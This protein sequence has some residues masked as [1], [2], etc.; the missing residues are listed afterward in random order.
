MTTRVYDASQV[1]MLFMGAIIDSGFADG[2]FLKIEQS[3]QDFEAVIG[4]DG[5]VTRYPT[6]TRHAKITIMLMQSS[7][8][9]SKLSAINNLDIVSHNGAGIGPMFVRDLLGTSIY[10]A[11][12]CWIA[13]A[14]DI[15]FDRAAGPREWKLECSDLIRFDGAN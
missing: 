8:G 4:T 14:P 7:T 3:H 12:H 13:Q 11:A 15:Q 9:N 6:L 2:P 10:T 1:S 5:E